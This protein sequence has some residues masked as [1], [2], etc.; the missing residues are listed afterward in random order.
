MPFVA[1]S[2]T[3]TVP[4]EFLVILRV[5][6]GV[7]FLIAVA[8]K[9]AHPG[10]AANLPGLFA[11]GP[12]QRAHPFYLA[13]IRALV[14]PHTGLVGA[15]VVAGELVV[16]VSLVSGV[17]T[18]LGALVAMWLVTNYMFAKG[19]WWWF[20]ASNDAACFF[21][22]LVLILGAAGRSFGVD[23]FLVRRW[24]RAWIW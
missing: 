15:L 8:S 22:A 4:R 12:F 13:F 23:Y 19:A 18:R 1:D 10:W 9:L 3:E 14:L 21:I 2:R 7:I 6:L 24:P 11:A 5:Y 20:P 16:G 17:A